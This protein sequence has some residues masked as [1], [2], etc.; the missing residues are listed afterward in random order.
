MYDETVRP[1]FRRFIASKVNDDGTQQRIDG[2]G[3]KGDS[4]KNA[5]RLQHHG[6]SSV[7]PEGS[8]GLM[9]TLG[10]RSDRPWILGLEHK[11]H[12]PTKLPGGGSALYDASGNIIKVIGDDVTFGFDAAKNGWTATAKGVS[13]TASDKKITI[14]T[15]GDHIVLNSNGKNVYLGDKDGGSTARVM[16]ESGVST[17]VYAKV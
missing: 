6:F 2:D 11:D 15:K 7:P 3:L 5:V 16:T 17:N 12:R 14:E 8:E 13:I 10:G 1:L 9:L 4:P